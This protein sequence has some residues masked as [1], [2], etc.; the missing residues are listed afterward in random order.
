LGRKWLLPWQPAIGHNAPP[1]TQ[2]NINGEDQ[3][4]PAVYLL[5]KPNPRCRPP[6]VLLEEPQVMLDVEP[7]AVRLPQ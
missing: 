4:R 3:P 1:Q 7:A 5:R 6:Q 2:L